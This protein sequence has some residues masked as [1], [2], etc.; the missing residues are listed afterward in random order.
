LT[1]KTFTLGDDVQLGLD[2]MPVDPSPPQGA[3][4]DAAPAGPTPTL[5]GAC[6]TCSA[7][8]VVD[9]EAGYPIRCAR[10]RDLGAVPGELIPPTQEETP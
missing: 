8:M 6:T 7:S 2:G 1:R 3:L 9:D 4:F 10:C 5:I